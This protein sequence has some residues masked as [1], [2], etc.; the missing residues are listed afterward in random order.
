MKNPDWKLNDFFFQRYLVCPAKYK[1]DFKADG[2]VSVGILLITRRSQLD[3]SVKF[4]NMLSE[5]WKNRLYILST[6]SNENRKIIKIEH[7]YV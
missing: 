4:W 7:F 1:A 5:C 3:H 2:F 6:S